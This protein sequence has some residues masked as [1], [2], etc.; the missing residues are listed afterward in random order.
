MPASQAVT[1]VVLAGGRSSRMGQDKAKLSGPFGDTM[2]SHVR[3]LLLDAGVSDI[4][5]LGGSEAPDALPD[6]TPFA[7]PVAAI[8]DYLQ[9]Q[10]AGSRHIF[11]PVDMPEM[12]VRLLAQLMSQAHWSYFENFYMPFLAVAGAYDVSHISRVGDLLRAVAVKPL[13][14]GSGDR[15]A[16]MNLNRPEEFRRWFSMHQPGTSAGS[17][18][19]V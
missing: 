16:F 18:D 9:Q 1:G 17:Y 11:M 12:S 5:V 3:Q 2:L 4:V 15:A 8:A 19:Y 7:G 13:P 10:P 6:R 14:L